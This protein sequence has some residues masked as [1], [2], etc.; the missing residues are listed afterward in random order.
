M[1]NRAFNTRTKMPQQTVVFS[2]CE[3]V[4]YTSNNKRATKNN[5]HKMLITA[6]TA[7]LALTREFHIRQTDSFALLHIDM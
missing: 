4:V 1:A 2:W 7:H 5:N 3:Q 6:V